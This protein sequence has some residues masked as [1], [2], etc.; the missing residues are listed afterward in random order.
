[1]T[2]NRIID[3][4]RSETHARRS[5][6]SSYGRS[7]S[8]PVLMIGSSE[9]PFAAG[10]ELPIQ[11][12]I[13]AFGQVRGYRW[14]MKK[15]GPKLA[16][17]GKSSPPE[18]NKWIVRADD[19]IGKSAARSRTQARTI[20]RQVVENM[21]GTEGIRL[22]GRLTADQP[23]VLTKRCEI[24]VQELG[25][26]PRVCRAK[27][28]EGASRMALDLASSD[29]SAEPSCEVHSEALQESHGATVTFLLRL[30]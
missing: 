4:P 20:I 18:S 26:V 3:W 7:G 12:W 16:S 15:P 19:R 21:I 28:W 23:T 24:R 1:M 10:E 2:A 22:A 11:G 29:A 25:S 8:P 27:G 5:R 14:V 30:A 17:E 6:L 13:S 9:G